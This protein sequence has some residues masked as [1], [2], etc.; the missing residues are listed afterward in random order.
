MQFTIL[1]EEFYAL[2]LN[3]GVNEKCRIYLCF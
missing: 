3:I 1:Y 2:L